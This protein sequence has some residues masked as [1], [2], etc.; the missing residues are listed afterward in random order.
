MKIKIYFNKNHLLT[1][2]RWI[3]G[4]SNFYCTLCTS[5]FACEYHDDIHLNKHSNPSSSIKSNEFCVQL[6]DALLAYR[7]STQIR[8]NPTSRWCSTMANIGMGAV[9][10]AFPLV[11][12]FSRMHATSA[13]RYQIYWLEYSPQH[14]FRSYWNEKRQRYFLPVNHIENF[15]WKNNQRENC[16]GESSQCFCDYSQYSLEACIRYTKLAYI[17]M[18]TWVYEE[19]KCWVTI[20][21]HELMQQIFDVNIVTANALVTAAKEYLSPFDLLW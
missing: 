9:L 15:F 8:R 18:L 17:F 2:A 10:L 6:L 5:I 21:H 11:P 13:N 19:K 14:T 4:I 3:D 1:W 16:Y 7:E 20:A 12:R